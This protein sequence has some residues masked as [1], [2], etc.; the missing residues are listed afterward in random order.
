MSQS[1]ADELGATR[2]PGR[3]LVLVR[4]S[5]AASARWLRK[6]LVAVSTHELDGWTGVTLAED[7][8][9][10]APPYDRGLEVLAARRVPARR[11][12]ALGFFDIDDC[13]VLTVQP[14]GWRAE[15]RWLVWKPG[16][17][18]CRT[19]DLP[20]LPAGLVIA[21]AGA[22][23]QPRDLMALLASPVGDPVGLLSS[24]LTLL[25]LPGAELLRVPGPEL[26]GRRDAGTVVEPSRGAVRRF[27]ELVADD[28]VAD[29]HVPD[30]RRGVR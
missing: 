25:R 17:G 11:R 5:A 20:P 1:V 24:V 19:P 12:P 4:G 28:P 18:L 29:G 10:S 27:D 2:R 3:G 9:R 30:G 21:T 15:Q 16:V 26:A 22:R 6:G 14:K 7:R 13:A 8:A 23:V